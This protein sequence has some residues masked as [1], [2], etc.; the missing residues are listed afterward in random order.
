MGNEAK[1]RLNLMA[2]QWN[3]TTSKRFGTGVAGGGNSTPTNVTAT[4]SSNETR[5]LLDGGG[6]SQDG[7]EMEMSFAGK[8]Y[9]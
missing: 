1:K 2:A 4:A 5:G 6:G 8:K 3:A 9:A 7:D